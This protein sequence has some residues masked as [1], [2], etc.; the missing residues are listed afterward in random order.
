MVRIVSVLY[1]LAAF[2]W[3]GAQSLSE[4]DVSPKVKEACANFKTEGN[5]FTNNT[6][7]ALMAAGLVFVLAFGLE[8]IFKVIRRLLGWDIIDLK[9]AETETPVVSVSLTQ[10]VAN[11]AIERALLKHLPK[12]LLEAINAVNEA[13]KAAKAS[14]EGDAKAK[15]KGQGGEEVMKKK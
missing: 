9:K 6:S 13:K 12:H 10:D 15:P 1:A 5:A 2:C 3:F 8:I 4:F 7:D 14:A 11:K